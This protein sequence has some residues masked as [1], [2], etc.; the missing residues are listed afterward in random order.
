M[1]LHSRLYLLSLYH[2]HAAG[3]SPHLLSW[4]QAGHWEAGP[5]SWRQERVGGAL[6][7][8]MLRPRRRW[9]QLDGDE[10]GMGYPGQCHWLPH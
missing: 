10:V 8:Q 1:A 3:G 6:P 5:E 7:P 2:G 4:G 9:G